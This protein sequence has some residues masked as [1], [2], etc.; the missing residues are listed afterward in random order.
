ML[1]YV[2]TNLFESPAQVL[3]NT[4]NTVGVMGKGI[5]LEFKN[6]YPEMFQ[7]Y[8]RFCERGQFTVGKLWIYRTNNKWVLNFPTKRNWRNKSRLEDIEL[9]LKKFVATYKDQGITSIA[10]PQLGVGNGGLDWENQ[11]K[12]LM[13]K[14]LSRLPIT[15][16]IHLYSGKQSRPEYEDLKE[17]KKWL[18]SDPKMLSINEF[19]T[20]LIQSQPES[21]FVVKGHRI[22]LVNAPITKEIDEVSA[23]F[24]TIENGQ[25]RYALSQANLTDFWSRMRQEGLVTTKELPN[26]I[27]L[28]GDAVLFQD[29]VMQLDYIGTTQITVNGHQEI[30]LTLKQGKLPVEK[31][32]QV[33]IG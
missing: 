18:Q 27:Q 2:K 33:E 1:I 6:L 31:I 21:P 25:T 9:G 15:V 19:K 14:Y 26:A 5:A 8:R 22:E 32:P 20:E 29:L 16:Y 3:V 12:P 24:M 11:V 13:E 10:F 17:T 30:A 23:V 7:E 4:V 28:N